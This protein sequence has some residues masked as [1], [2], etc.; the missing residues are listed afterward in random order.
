MQKAP[1][2][3]PDDPQFLSVAV[4]GLPNVGK[5]TLVN[6]LVGQTVQLAVVGSVLKT[7]Q[8]L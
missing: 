4:V 1:Q 6:Q 2:H 8:L 7:D 5:S 3:Q